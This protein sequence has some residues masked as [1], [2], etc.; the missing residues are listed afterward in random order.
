MC[1]VGVLGQ[2]EETALAAQTV[3]WLLSV[4]GSGT[5]PGR[6][7]L[8]GGQI[9]PEKLSSACTEGLERICSSKKCKSE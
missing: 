3:P 5:R 9:H 1:A 7:R 2:D 8:H 4:G 6:A